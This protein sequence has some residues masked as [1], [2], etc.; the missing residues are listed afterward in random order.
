MPLRNSATSPRPASWHSTMTATRTSSAAVI[1]PASSRPTPTTSSIPM[2]STSP[3]T[4]PPPPTSRS[5]TMATPVCRTS[6]ACSMAPSA[7]AGFGS[8]PGEQFLDLTS[9][10][11]WPQLPKVYGSTGTATAITTTTT[12]IPA[13]PPTRRSSPS[14]TPSTLPRSPRGPTLR[15][16]T[17]S[18]PTPARPEPPVQITDGTFFA[19]EIGLTEYVFGS[20]DGAT[21]HIDALLD[22][23]TARRPINSSAATSSS[24]AWIPASKSP[25]PSPE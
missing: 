25:R 13:D 6:P 10:R 8:A 2:T 21:G 7:W 14:G 9:C 22:G 24:M 3:A 1:T 4:A 12:P 20:H 17:P 18:S 19:G 15:T 23:V 5:S 11:R 16:Q